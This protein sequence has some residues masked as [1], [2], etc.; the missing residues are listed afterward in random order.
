MDNSATNYLAQ[1]KEFLKK[2]RLLKAAPLAVLA[3][4][5]LHARPN[6]FTPNAVQVTN[7]SG[8]GGSSTLT[9]LSGSPANSGHGI[10]L[11]GAA[12]QILTT[13]S[14]NHTDCVILTWRWA[15]TGGGT[16][17]GATLPL[18]W[19]F[20]IAGNN[21]PNLT[22]N[23]W[24]MNVTFNSIGS[25]S[26][27]RSRLASSTANVTNNS[28]TF[29]CSTNC[30]G[31]IVGSGP[32]NTPG[33]GVTMTSWIVTLQVDSTWNTPGGTLTVTVPSTTSIDLNA[34]T[35]TPVAGVPAVSNTVLAMLAT[36][37]LAMGSAFVMRP[38]WGAPRG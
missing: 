22:V 26:P 9:P 6:F 10:T 4:T 13:T 8:S 33:A 19:N 38:N 2:S 12:R 1:A 11:F 16:F 31:N 37:L 28:T 14:A 17:D 23:D 18:A 30:V 20:S 32:V 5:A 34:A 29:S 25:V 3:V 35:T 7:C 27:I 21:P 15:G 36:A 24:V